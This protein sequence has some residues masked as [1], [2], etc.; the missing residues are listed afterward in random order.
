[1]SIAHFSLK[2]ILIYVF[3]RYDL[4]AYYHINLDKM[5]YVLYN[6]YTNTNSVLVFHSL[7]ARTHLQELWVSD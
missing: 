5:Y 6:N 2:L 1:M 7:V 4:L 3:F